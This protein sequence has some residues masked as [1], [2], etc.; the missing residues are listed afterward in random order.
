MKALTIRP[1]DGY[2]QDTL[3]WIKFKKGEFDEALAKI[4]KASE[5]IPDEA[6]VY[7]HLGDIYSAKNNKEKAQ[8]AYK[9]AVSLAKGKDKD[10]IQKVEH[11]LAILEGPLNATK[12]EN[13][14]PSTEKA[15]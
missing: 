13:R 15:E 10:M 4:E 2:I 1:N 5:L 12:K 11:K 6:I 14:L 9:K 3:A 8:V 7:E